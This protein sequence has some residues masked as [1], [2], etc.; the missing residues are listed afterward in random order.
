[1]P[2][3]TSMPLGV[4]CLLPLLPCLSGKLLIFTSELKQCLLWETFP[5]SPGGPWDCFA[6]L[7]SLY[8]FLLKQHLCFKDLSVPSLD[9][10]LLEGM[11]PPFSSLGFFHTQH[12]PQHIK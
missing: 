3:L 4:L 8:P 12:G 1:M 9:Y 5:T 7:H 2:F 6:L 10:M 11:E